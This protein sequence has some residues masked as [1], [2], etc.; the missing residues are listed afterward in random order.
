MGRRKQANPTKVADD[1]TT[2]ASTSETIQPPTTN[3][4][5]NGKTASD[6]KSAL[7]FSISAHL[8]PDTKSSNKARKSSNPN[9]NSTNSVSYQTAQ[10]AYQTLMTNLKQQEAL[11]KSMGFG[12][13]S[14]A[15]FFMNPFFGANMPS[16]FDFFSGLQSLTQK[17]KHKLG[18]FLKS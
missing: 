2:E 4:L 10:K 12:G 1:Y 6:K 5:T 15:A 11:M 16:S 7:N 13:N 18:E 3:G 8:Q 14:A 9:D 17:K